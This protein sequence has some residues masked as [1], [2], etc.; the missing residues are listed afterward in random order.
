LVHNVAAAQL[1]GKLLIESRL[2]QLC[3]AEDAEV[4]KFP[5]KLSLT[6]HKKEGLRRAPDIFSDR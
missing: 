5:R 4:G 2:P 3:C 6:S 1:N